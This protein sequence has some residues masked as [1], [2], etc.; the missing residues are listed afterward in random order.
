MSS[1]QLIGLRKK[2]HQLKANLKRFWINLEVWLGY[3]YWKWA[4]YRRQPWFPDM[5]HTQPCPKHGGN[6]K[7]TGKTMGG[8][9]YWCEK[10]R[11]GFFVRAKE[12]RR[13]N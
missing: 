6:R 8:A 13:L 9:Y 7:L 4:T 3:K 2:W 1:K 11:D 12:L 5:P 10:C